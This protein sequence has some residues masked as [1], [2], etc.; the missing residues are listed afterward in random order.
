MPTQLKAAELREE[1]T[2]RKQ[3]NATVLRPLD[4][5]EGFVFA[6][7]SVV[8]RAPDA[9]LP[10]ATVLEHVNRLA[11]TFGKDANAQ[12]RFEQFLGAL[13]ETVAGRVGAGDW[14]IPIQNFS[15]IVGIACDE[16]MFLSGTG[17][18]TAM[19][20]H[21]TPQQRY[22]VFN[23]FRSIQTEQALPTWEK[24]FAVV[25]DGELHP[26]DVFCVSNRDLARFIASEE[27]N[28]VLSTLPPK[29][30]AAKIRQYFPASAD[31]TL[32]ILQSVDSVGAA[33]EFAQPLASVSLDHLARTTTETATLLED[34]KPK[35]I[36]GILDTVQRMRLPSKRLAVGRSLW[37]MTSSSVVV[38]LRMVLGG[39]KWTAR[40]TV[41]LARKDKRTQIVTAVRTGADRGVRSILGR[42][43]RLPKTTKT[44]MVAALGIVFVLA[45]GI[46]VM[47]R[48]QA[49][50]VELAAYEE[51]VTAVE[52][53]IEK[54]AGAVIY[55]DES[56][57]RRLYAEALALA[58]ALPTD[59]DDRVRTAA[60][61]QSQISGAFNELRHLIN[62]PQP[63]LLGELDPAGGASGRGVFA[64]EGG[65][66]VM[67]TDK[68]L[69]LLD[70][71]NRT[72][73]AVETSNGEVG[74]P[75]E[76]ASEN[77]E[78][79]FLDDRPGVSRLDLENKL[80]QITN[81]QPAAGARWTDLSL[82]GGKMYVLEPSSG[83]IVK[84]NRAGSDF[85]G[86]T[87]W[88][89]AK[90][91]DLSNAVSIAI[92]ATV[93]V[94]KQDGQLIR[95]VGGSEVGW[96]QGTADPALTAATDVWTAADSDYVYVLEPSTQRLV[97][98]EKE[99]GDLVTQYRSDAF[100][101]L[102]DFLVDESSKIVYLLAGPKLYSITASHL[103]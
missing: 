62:I 33:S 86:G 89:R 41:S 42:F 59:T 84:Y 66:Y 14:S 68:R 48:A 75:V 40:T 67:G 98:Y 34:Q 27:L 70:A 91:T 24:A 94:L 97:V 38:A 63:T 10:A 4:G 71:T 35:P 92:D 72:L 23:L 36:A 50:S 74:A 16:Q 80:L 85:D 47:Q 29:G 96:T 32:L 2:D 69:Y 31:L 52:A 79:L 22:Q 78:A 99:N 43:N 13:N 102:T 61:L 19:F 15:A 57:A 64:S 83:Q 81:V 103:K 5:R 60:D 20:L 53:A 54:A 87:K 3:H 82:Y 55:K 12:H 25:L 11:E 37:R 76:I 45:T 90:T 46:T 18:L 7:V 21:R 51:K 93:F 26:G 9:S 56:Q 101:G 1:S 8:G 44:L 88:I 58:T 39:A 95:F 100:Q 30:A 17:D 65:I 77:G 49:R 6:L 73:S 28:T